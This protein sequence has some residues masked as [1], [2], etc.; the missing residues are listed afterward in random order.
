MRYIRGT[1]DLGLLISS[2][3]A[4]E[5]V[6]CSDV[7]LGIGPKSCLPKDQFVKLRMMTGLATLE[8]Y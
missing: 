1:A 4:E 3:A 7:H 5:C 8:Q 6:G 2:D